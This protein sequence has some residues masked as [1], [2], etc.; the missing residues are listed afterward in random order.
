[1]TAESAILA[2]GCFWGAQDLIR[3][4]PG[5]ISTRTGYS[6]DDGTPNPTYRNHGDHAEAVEVRFIPTV[7]S[8]RELLA[9]FFQIHDPTTLNR[10]G[11]DIG[12]GYRSAVFATNEGQRE[13]ALDVISQLDESGVLPGKVVTEVTDAGEFWEAEQE[14]QDYLLKHPGGYSCHFVRPEWQL[15]QTT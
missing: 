5:V 15:A 11:N 13:T 2:S 8:Y 7:I 10:Q 9:F 3:A 12:R 14:H 1:M 6:G 4:L